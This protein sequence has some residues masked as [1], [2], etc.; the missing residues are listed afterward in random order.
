M[1]ASS[2][3]A[4]PA[5]QRDADGEQPGAVSDV[6]PAGERDAQGCVEDREGGTGEEA[7][8]KIIQ[9]ELEADLLGGD[10]EEIA[11]GVSDESG[12]K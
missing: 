5:P 11:V 9:P 1:R 12:E 8:L 7:E 3:C 10:A 4:K 2:I 6:G